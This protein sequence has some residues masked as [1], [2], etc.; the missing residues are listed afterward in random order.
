[1]ADVSNDPVVGT[2]QF[3]KEILT[4]LGIPGHVKLGHEGTSTEILSARI[5]AYA[6]HFRQLWKVLYQP[7]KE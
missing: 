2:L 3:T 5:D 1:M 7:G 6:K 4:E